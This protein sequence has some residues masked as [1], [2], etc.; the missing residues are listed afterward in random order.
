MR[1]VTLLFLSMLVVTASGCVSKGR[2]QKEVASLQGQ[3][4]Q[5]DTS[6]RAQETELA[7]LRSPRAS[8]QAQPVTG[9]FAGAT[10]RTPSG[11][12]LPAAQ[13]QKALKGAGYYAG[14]VDGKI[15]PDSREAIRSFQRDNGLTA[16]G[17]CGKQ[18][19]SKLKTHLNIAG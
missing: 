15:G 4:A 17:V 16:D 19:W 14:L 9:T 13:I 11:F 6:L 1:T 12:E 5:M 7:Q 8:Q 2:H 18:T 10:Y 3:I